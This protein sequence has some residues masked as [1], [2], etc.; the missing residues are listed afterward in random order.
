MK[1]GTITIHRNSVTVN[2]NVW[3]SDFEIAEL[4]G[5]T[6]AA[7]SSNIKS[8]FKTG[9]L[10]EY[11]VS[12]YIRLENGNRADVYNLEMITALAF[13]LNSLPASTFREWLIKRAATATPPI[14]LQVG[15]D[16][17]LC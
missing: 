10:K 6:L 13:R 7:V 14:I 2:G 5:V 1:R 8:I 17:F 12:R 4:F 16:S 11:S 15:R 9:V 3:M